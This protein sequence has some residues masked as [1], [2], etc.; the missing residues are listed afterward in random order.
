MVIKKRLL[1]LSFWW[2]ASLALANE[3]LDKNYYLVKN[4]SEEWLVYDQDQKSYVPYVAEEHSNEPSV[5]VLIN[6]ESNRF[7]ELL[8]YVE[9]DNY[10]FFNGSLQ[11]RQ[12][13]GT[14]QRF[15]IDSLLKMYPNPQL[16]LTLYG[17]AGKAGKKVLVGHRK[18]SAEK[19][20]TIEDA[21]FLVLRPRER[22]PLSNFFTLSMLLLIAIAALLFSSYPRAFSRFYSIYDLLSLDP[23]DESF[24]VNKPFSRTNLLFVGFTS[25]LMAYL[26][27]FVQSKQYELFTFKEFISPE[28]TLSESWLDFGTVSVVVLVALLGKY[29]GLLILGSLYQ[30]DTITKRHYFK[31]IQSSLLFYTTTVLVVSVC[32]FYIFDWA[33]LVKYFLIIPSIIFY[34]FRTALLFFTIRNMVTVKNLY[35]ISY[36]CIAEIIPLIIGIRYAL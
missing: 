8:V 35:V 10:L 31:V 36:L 16:L 3:P 13:G 27:F 1:L 18:V 21:S 6:L 14:W 33:V 26:F 2:V 11:R 4:Y 28:Q 9:K 7:Y 5:N 19:P 23:R 29:L 20:I 17:S 22:S 30:L 34:L 24:L 25:L 12:M 32:S 15:K